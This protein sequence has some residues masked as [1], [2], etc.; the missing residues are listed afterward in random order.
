MTIVFVIVIFLML[1]FPHELGHLLAAKLSGM[2]VE[3]FSLGFG[4]RLWSKK[5][6]ETEYVISL[7]P[8]GGY[9]KIAGMGPG[10]EH[11]EGG[12]YSKQLGKKLAVVL[13]G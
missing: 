10:E 3:R 12:F 9:V 7:F 6:K 13:S 8:I 1:I 5:G 4:P 11:V 2:H